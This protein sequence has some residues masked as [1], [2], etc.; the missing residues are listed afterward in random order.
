[1][2][3][4]VFNGILKMLN[5]NSVSQSS[6]SYQNIHHTFSMTPVKQ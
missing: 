4:F 2:T 5:L 3:Y 1:M 6:C